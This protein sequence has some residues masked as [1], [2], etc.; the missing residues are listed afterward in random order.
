MFGLAGRTLNDAQSL[1]RSGRLDGLDLA[2]FFALGAMVVVNFDV[3]MVTSGQPSGVVAELFQGRAAATFVVLAGLGFGLQAT[4]MGP[5]RFRP[6]ALRRAVFLLLAGLLNM[7]IFPADIIHYYGAYFLLALPLA[8]ARGWVLWVCMLLLGLGFVFLVL[9]LNYDAGW[10]WKNLHY[11]GLWTP[12]GFVRN[13][14]FNGWHPVVPWFSFFLFGLWLSR[15]SLSRRA[16]QLTALTLGSAT[17][18]GIT[19]ASSYLTELVITI[20]AEAV[21]LVGVEPVPPGPLYLIAGVGAASAAIGACLLLAPVLN[22][23][24][25]LRWLTRPGRQTLTFYIAHIFIGMGLMEGLGLLGTGDSQMALR[26]SAGFVVAT[27]L[28]ANLW[29]LRFAHGPLEWLMRKL[30]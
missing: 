10:D 28:I 11:E 4:R 23:I 15:A 22:K 17:L 19:W 8:W 6:L 25:I 14:L 24:G 9:V 27:V 16:V 12:V 5:D 7:L 1:Q 21:H 13:L 18:V 3:V 26:W 29:S 30:T 2:R 20:D